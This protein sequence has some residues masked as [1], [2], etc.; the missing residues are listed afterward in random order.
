MLIEHAAEIRQ[1]KHQ[2]FNTI[3]IIPNNPAEKAKP[4]M[5]TIIKIIAGLNL[6]LV[7]IVVWLKNKLM[8]RVRTVA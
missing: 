5:P 4:E 2:A 1:Y 3:P 6:S 8:L 7:W